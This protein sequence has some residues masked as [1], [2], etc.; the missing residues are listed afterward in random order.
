MSLARYMAVASP[1]DG[2][3]HGHDDL[4]HLAAAQPGQKLFYRELLGT[5]A[6]HRADEAVEDVV[7][8]VILPGALK[9]LHVAGGSPPHRWW[10]GPAWRWSRW[11]KAPPRCSSGRRGSGGAGCGRSG[12]PRPAPWRR[13]PTCSAPDRPSGSRPCGRCPETG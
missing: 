13:R 3:I 6:V 10:S 2:G 12:W 8:A 5:D 4:L 7:E 1:L 9:G 11:G